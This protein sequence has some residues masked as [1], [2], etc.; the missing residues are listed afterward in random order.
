MPVR[1]RITLLFTLL[2]FVI[3]SLVCASAYYF[4]YSSR[5][6]TNKVRLRNRAITIGR[7]LSRSDVFSNELVQRIDSATSMAYINKVIQ[8][9]D[10]KN[11]KI[12]EYTS[13]L[14]TQFELMRHC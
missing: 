3:L 11:Q 10:H 4:F 6:H 5:I 2:V 7:L 8:A 13:L 9:Y 12:Y 14:A 1:I